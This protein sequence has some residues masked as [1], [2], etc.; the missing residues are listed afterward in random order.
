MYKPIARPSCIKM[1]RYVLAIDPGPTQSG[2]TLIETTTFK[3]VKA[4]KTDNF[5]VIAFLKEAPEEQFDCQVVIEMVGHYGSGMP[6]GA[7]VFETC[8]WIGRFTQQFLLIG[9]PVYRLKRQA[10]KLNLCRDSRAKDGNISQALI[11]RF[12]PGQRN[13]GKGTKKE[14]GWF[15][16]FK[17]DIWQSYALGVS[18]IDLG[19]EKLEEVNL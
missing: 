17:A 5:S 10:V 11:D 14:P 8:I 1:P 9:L 13:R 12:A 16:G 18:S 3:P 19:N 4:L 7:E 15:Y 2:V 6:A